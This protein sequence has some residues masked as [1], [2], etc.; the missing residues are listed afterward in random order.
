MTNLFTE[1][2]VENIVTQAI[3]KGEDYLKKQNWR[4]AE[5]I[6]R[7]ILKVAPAC[8][9]A[10]TMLCHILVNLQRHAEAVPFYE[11]IAELTPDDYASLNDLALCYASAGRLDESIEKLEI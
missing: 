4:D 5:A 9:E 11:K 6:T 2:E 3:V 10:L 7:Q 8:K 1:K